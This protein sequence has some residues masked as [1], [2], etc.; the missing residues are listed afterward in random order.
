M[1]TDDLGNIKEFSEKPTG[2]KLKAMAVDTS[3]F[4]LVRSQLPKNL[5]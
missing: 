2:E 3:K 5:I 1:R 4:G